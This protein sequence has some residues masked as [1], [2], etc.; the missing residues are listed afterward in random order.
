MAYK[1]E[2]ATSQVL[3]KI[4]SADFVELARAAPWHSNF[5]SHLS[6]GSWEEERDAL[7]DRI[8]AGIVWLLLGRDLQD[9]WNHLCLCRVGINRIPNLVRTALCDEDHSHIFAVH[10]L[11]ELLFDVLLVRLGAHDQVVAHTLPVDVAHACQDEPGDSVLIGNDTHLHVGLAEEL[12]L[13]HGDEGV[14][15]AEGGANA[16]ES[17]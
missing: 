16:A 13:A 15:D 4:C 2:M 14:V 6:H 7:H 5:D 1:I 3:K 8:L 17:H 11:V 9:S 12:L 10:Q